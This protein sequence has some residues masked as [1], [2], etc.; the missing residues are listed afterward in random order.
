MSSAGS[1]LSVSNGVARRM[2]GKWIMWLA[3][4]A[5]LL[6][7]AFLVRFNR[8]I[9]PSFL[10][11][12]PSMS[13]YLSLSPSYLKQTSQEDGGLN[14]DKV[15]TI[16]SSR[17]RCIN[18]MEQQ[19][20]LNYS[21]DFSKQPVVVLFHETQGVDKCAVGCTFS[22]MVSHEVKP[23]A[24][25]GIH[26]QPGVARVLRSMESAVYYGVNDVATAH[27]MGYNVVMT[28]SLSSDVP[29]GYF[30]W[31]EYD[32]MAPLE[33]KTEKS[34]AAAFISNCGANNFR[35]DALVELQNL[36]SVNKI[37]ALQ[38][39][40]FSLA[41]ENSIE[42]DY[43]TEKYWQSLV[44]G[45]VPVVIGAPNIQDF[46]PASNTVIHIKNMEEVK[47][48]ATEMKYLVSNETVYNETLRWKVVGPS[49]A[50]KALVDMSAVH[51]SCRLC[52]HLATKIRL[53]EEALLDL[54][55]KRSCR[56]TENSESWFHLY[57]RE[58]NR[59]EMESLYLR[60]NNLTMRALQEAII[61]TFNSKTHVPI[62][63]SERPTVLKGD[64]SLKVYKVY[65]MGST[66]HDALYTRQLDTDEDL[67]NMVEN[68]PCLK[69]EVIFV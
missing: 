67:K 22:P 48:A 24:A 68:T 50:F 58:R 36:G 53:Q 40:K 52:I 3:L 6:E 30:S 29:V 57:V 65:P 43:V 16:S 15:A 33:K 32:I 44:A 19:D 31:A 54:S 38:G 51:S 45:T 66:Q 11:S 23:D 64:N 61:E 42:E 41:F 46:A 13:Q 47:F 26:E 62:W 4:F 49:D 7:L 69:L 12:L 59:F 21:R 1:R 18:L 56:C 27:R 17:Q 37:K 14:D 9:G 63:K 8:H 35:L 39:Y 25:F 60:S 28:T 2:L 55:K 10:S 20:A 5:F 34:M